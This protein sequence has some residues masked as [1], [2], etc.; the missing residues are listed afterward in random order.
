MFTS[1][2]RGKRY[3]IWILFAFF[4][5]LAPAGVFAADSAVIVMYHRFGESRYPSTNTTVAQFKTHLQELKDGNYVVKPVPEILAAIRS[6][7]ELPDKTVGITIDDAFLSVYRTGWPMLR[8]AGFPFTLF[9]ATE[10]L[11]HGTA[12][13]MSWDQLR[14][15]QESGVT[16]G[17]QTATHLHMPHATD[18]QNLADLKASNARFNTELGFVPK[19]I[20]YPYGEFSRA[21]GKVTRAAGFD[22]GF[23]QHSGAIYKNSDF[24]YLPRF[25]FNEAFGDLQRFRLAVRALPFKVSDLTPAD[26][27][28]KGKQNPPPFGFTV[29][30]DAINRLSRI[31]C[32]ATRQGKVSVE[33][34]GERRIEVRAPEAFPP[35]RTRMNCTLLE[36]NGRWR[37]LGMQYLVP[38]P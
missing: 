4:A 22:I 3:L 26:P 13:Y 1:A 24:L 29:D 34:L 36:K 7:T 12:G 38:K 9:V 8:N 19:I 33:R 21:V 16:I 37:W 2:V 31:T 23:G 17:S 5:A 28:L 27:Y 15:L 14:E 11:D 32:Y 30:G 10:P 6:G 25:A 20:A 18:K 35:G